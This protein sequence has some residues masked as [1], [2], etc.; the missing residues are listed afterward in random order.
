MF[1]K[2]DLAATTAMSIQACTNKLLFGRNFRK[3]TPTVRQSRKL[4]SSTKTALQNKCASCRQRMKAGFHFDGNAIQCH[5][6]TVF[7]S[8]ILARCFCL[9]LWQTSHNCA[10]PVH[11]CDADP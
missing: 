9:I 4:I 6:V 11:F 3:Q 8:R 2:R 10:P 1:S 5:S 7:M